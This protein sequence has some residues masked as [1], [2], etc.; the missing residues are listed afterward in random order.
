MT[1]FLCILTA[2]ILIPFTAGA[3][4]FDNQQKDG[5]IITQGMTAF[6]LNSAAVRINGRDVEIKRFE[7]NVP[8]KKVLEACLLTAEKKGSITENNP[9]I[10]LAANALF[11]GAGS[12]IDADSF[13]YIFTRDKSGAADFVVAGASGGITEILKAEIAGCGSA[14]Q[15]YDDGIRHF[16]GAKRVLSLEFMAGGKTMNFGNFYMIR[17]AGI[18]EIRNYYS[19]EFARKG[20]VV[21]NKEYTEEADRYILKNGNRELVVNLSH[22]QNG[23]IVVFVM[24]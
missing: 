16:S 13:G 10:W 23:E 14:Q 1:R 9:Y 19:G 7:S 8:V 6:R 24:G 5:E 21:I 22:R 4:V 18:L 2:V 12:G 3:L 11:K 20:F 17:N 15:V